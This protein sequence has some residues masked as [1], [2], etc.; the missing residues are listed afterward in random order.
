MDHS[1]NILD[2]STNIIKEPIAD[3]P[4]IK[5]LIK[6]LVCSGGGINGF[7]FYSVFKE[8]YVQQLWDFKNIQT[9][10]GTSVGTLVG[11]LIL[12]ANSW[13]EIDNY[14]I[15]RPWENVFKFDLPILFESVDRRGV[16]NIQ[17]I[18]SIISPFI[19][20]RDKTTDITMQEFY[21]LTNV[22]F[23]C[24]VTEINSH[25]QIDVSHK[26]HPDWKLVEAIYASCALPI[27]FAPLL[28][29]GLCY[30]DGSIIKNCSIAE[31]LHNG[32][33]PDETLAIYCVQQP[34]P[35]EPID[36]ESTIF[37]YIGC[38]MKNIIYRRTSH[39]YP[40]VKYTF[41][42]PSMSTTFTSIYELSNDKEKRI[43]LLESG[44]QYVKM[45]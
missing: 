15:H 30:A 31:N 8:S 23:H 7:L 3:E 38:I 10:Y 4:S 2:V 16:Y 35:V 14:L 44:K 29:D 18:T 17:H 33:D 43:E 26:T 19:L 45:D 24:I 36:E 5:P 11:A 39:V 21:E 34:E 22:D 9:Y 41:K 28:K 42:V 6:H 27:A 13:E 20:A 32:A 25:T 12:L 37:D 1:G 40:D